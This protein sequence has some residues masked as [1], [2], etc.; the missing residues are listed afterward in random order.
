MDER[1]HSTLLYDF[2]GGLLTDKQREIFESYF[3]NDLSL[4]EIG[5]PAGISRQAVSDL[6]KRTKNL[7]LD[8]EA[9]LGLVARHMALSASVE[10]LEQCLSGIRNGC[11]NGEWA[12]ADEILAELRERL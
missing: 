7:L 11:T 8:Y 2:Y 6:L 3:L 4:R 10:K 12:V 5:E 1:L 9:R